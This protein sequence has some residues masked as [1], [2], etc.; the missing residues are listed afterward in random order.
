[1]ACAILL[2]ATLSATT[3][4]LV[5]ATFYGAAA[6]P[7][8]GIA[9]AHANDKLAS[10]QYVPASSTLL[11]CYGLGAVCGPFTASQVMVAI[12][13]TGLFVFLASVGT[14]AGAF[15]LWRILR[16]APTLPAGK[17]TFVAT[18]ATTPA[19]LDL[20]AGQDSERTS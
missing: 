1:L 15:V 20:A 10:D 3:L 6:L 8:Y 7:I 13:P 9:V 17:G 12:G 19:A 18:P 4:L 5:I 11:L 16:R 2:A 14:V